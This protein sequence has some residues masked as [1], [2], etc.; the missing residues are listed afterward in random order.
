MTTIRS[1][2]LP[3]LR[4]AAAA[5]LL[6]SMHAGATAPATLPTPAPAPAPAPAARVAVGAEIAFDDLIHYVGARIKVS[7]KMHT[8][9]EGVLTGASSIAINLQVD[10]PRSFLLGM[11][12][13]NIVKVVLLAD[14]PAKP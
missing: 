14:A 7:T 9:R 11:P 13:E 12:R 10:G 6:T 1:I 8:E 2:R 5:L 4:L 3:A